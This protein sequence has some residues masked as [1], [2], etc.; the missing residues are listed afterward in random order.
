[1]NDAY[2]RNEKFIKAFNKKCQEAF[3]KYFLDP[4]SKY[5]RIVSF[6][7]QPT[8]GDDCVRLFVTICPKGKQYPTSGIT[9]CLDQVIFNPN[10]DPLSYDNIEN[11]KDFLGVEDEEDEDGADAD[12][13]VEQ[14][15]MNAKIQ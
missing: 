4:K 3:Q 8:D 1:M 10:D 14:M 7:L 9:L 13:I 6:S 15:L 11:L 2:A 12:E 5:Y